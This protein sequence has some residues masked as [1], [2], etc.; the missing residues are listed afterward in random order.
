M[1][2]YTADEARSGVEFVG[3]EREWRLHTSFPGQELLLLL[4]LK[5]DDFTHTHAH[6]HRSRRK[7]VKNKG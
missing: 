2:W 3:E 4:N 7:V 6:S 1:A 5:F